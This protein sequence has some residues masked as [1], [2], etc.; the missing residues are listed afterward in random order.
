MTGILQTESLFL[1]NSRKMILD[2]LDFACSTAKQKSRKSKRSLIF[3]FPST[4]I[5]L[6]RIINFILARWHYSG[7]EIFKTY[8]EFQ[9]SKP[10]KKSTPK[11]LTT[12][13]ALQQFTK[14]PQ[15]TVTEPKTEQQKIKLNRKKKKIPLLSSTQRSFWLNIQF[16]TTARKQLDFSSSTYPEIPAQR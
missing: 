12:A 13:E 7:T 16:L 5:K 2:S 10:M 8:S 15:S 4:A 9:E 1:F 11:H 14:Q 6:T 3:F